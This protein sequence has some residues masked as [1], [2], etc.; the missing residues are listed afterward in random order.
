MCKKPLFL[1]YVFIFIFNLNSMGEEKLQKIELKIERAI[2]P[3]DSSCGPTSLKMALSFFKDDKSIDEIKKH[4]KMFKGIGCYDSHLALGAIELGYTPIVYSFNRRIFHPSWSDLNADKL[5]E[6]LI[7]KKKKLEGEK[8]KPDANLSQLRKDLISIEGYIE[9]L[10]KGV[11]LHLSPLSRDLILKYLKEGLPV[12]VALDMSYLYSAPNFD[13]EFEMEHTTH[14]V[15][16]YGFD[17]SDNTFLIA[18]PWYEIKLDNKNGKYKRDTDIIINAI[19][20]AD[21][22]NDADLLIIKKGDKK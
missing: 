6:K 17:P 12:I 11:E 8:K 15:V 13:D 20:Y 16:I 2:Q 9:L 7:E 14:F 22:C 21:Y 19:L 10:K 1:F 18:D 4:V 3:D 5:L